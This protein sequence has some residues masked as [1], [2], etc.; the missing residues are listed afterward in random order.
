MRRRLYSRLK[1][2]FRFLV[3]AMWPYQTTF[4]L[5]LL[6]TELFCQAVPSLSFANSI[7]FFLV[8]TREMPPWRDSAWQR[9]R[10]RRS[11]PHKPEAETDIVGG[12]KNRNT[13]MVVPVGACG[14]RPLQAPRPVVQ[15]P[16][17]REARLTRPN[18]SPH[19]AEP[20][21]DCV[22]MSSSFSIFRSQTPLLL[23]LPRRR[24]R[25]GGTLLGNALAREA[26]LR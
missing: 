14:T 11:A 21:S 2:S 26:P 10:P 16:D 22:V 20:G 5:C 12:A 18:E 6:A 8:A 15:D 9:R 4:S 25:P 3:A 17:Q 23:S 24:C 19:R 1:R 7:S 13:A